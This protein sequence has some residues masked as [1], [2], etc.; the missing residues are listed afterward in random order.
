MSFGDSNKFSIPTVYKGIYMRSK[1]ETKVALFLDYL[2][3]KWEYEPKTFLLSNGITYKPDFFLPEHKQWV[4]VKGVVSENNFKISKCF[5]KDTEQPIIIISSK[6][7]IYFDSDYLPNIST[8]EDRD[9]N[10]NGEKG[11]QLG[12]CRKCHTYFI[13][14]LYG[15]FHCRKC[16]MHEGDHDIISSIGR[17]AWNS[18][19]NEIDFS[20]INS[21][22]Q[23]IKN[24]GTRV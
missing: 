21:I 3:I 16:G 13:C 10:V 1:L 20:D 8:N 17:D 18:W 24:N 23:W 15:S 2:K 6:D 7:V 19:N 5:V 11:F 14:S 9:N 12:K 22:K 4:E